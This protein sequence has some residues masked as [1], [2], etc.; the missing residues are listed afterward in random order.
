MHGLREEIVSLQDTVKGKD[1]AIKSL[2]NTIMNSGKENERLAEMV[3]Q[4]K[5]KLI[6]ENV[7]HTSYAAVLRSSTG[8]TVFAGFKTNCDCLLGFVQDHEEED[9]FFLEIQQ[10]SDPENIHRIAVDD[11]DEIEHVEGTLK[12]YIHFQRKIDRTSSSGGLGS[13]LK[14]KIL[15]SN[16]SKKREKYEQCT[17][18]FESKF[19]NKLIENF[20][21]VLEIIEQQE[22]D[23]NE[24]VDYR[25]KQDRRNNFKNKRQ[26]TI[27]EEEEPHGKGKNVYLVENYMDKVNDEDGSI[28]KPAEKKEPVLKKEVMQRK[29]S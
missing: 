9:E 24:Y 11:I 28:K 18:L 13:M 20:T 25:D 21:S 2:G 14:K 10:K 22:V 27:T 3:S 15:G 16:P 4:L 5:N 19:V 26:A 7:F 23:L 12:F 17:E 29:M 1:E 8:S 6:I